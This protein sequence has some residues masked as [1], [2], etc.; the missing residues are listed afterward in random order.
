MIKTASLALA[1]AALLAVTAQQ[2]HAL[3]VSPTFDVFGPLPEA[4]FSGSGIPNHSVAITSFVDGANTITLGL[5]ATQRFGEPPVTNDGA[6]TFTAQAGGFPGM[7]TLARWNF[8]YFVK[9]V[10]GGTLADYAINLL[11][12]LD[13][14]A[15]TDESAHGVWDLS[16]SFPTDVLNQDSQNLGFG[17][18]AAGF[19]PFVIAPGFGPFDP[20]AAGEY[21]FALRVSSLGGS[22]LGESAIQVNTVPEPI[23]ASLFGIGALGLAIG[24]A[25]RRRRK[26]TA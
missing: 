23:S 5:T 3:P 21:T 4:T 18:L 17:F 6:G 20:T 24:G 7:P 12:D 16:A 9:I 13:P 1:C 15:G 10:G 22:P 14:G 11:Y 25:R 19:P 2:A 26:Q 8:D